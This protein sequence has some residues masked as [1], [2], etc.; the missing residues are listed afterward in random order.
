MFSTSLGE[1]TFW[2]CIVSGEYEQFQ[3]F[4]P[5]CSGHT[6]APEAGNS[7]SIATSREE[8]SIRDDMME[9]MVYAW[10]TKANGTPKQQTV[11]H[12]M[13]TFDDFL[14]RHTKMD[15]TAAPQSMVS[16]NPAGYDSTRRFHPDRCA[17]R[18]NRCASTL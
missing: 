8:C 15:S 18:G 7:Q 11:R 13:A 16:A 14:A 1:K 5:V 4:L 9:Y 12:Q 2:S 3:G 6:G 10:R 17:V